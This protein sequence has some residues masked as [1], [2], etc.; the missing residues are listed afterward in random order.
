MGGL[1]YLLQSQGMWDE[2]PISNKWPKYIY[3]YIWAKNINHIIGQKTLDSKHNRNQNIYE[4][5]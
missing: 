4:I 2:L 5:H 3:I 1:T